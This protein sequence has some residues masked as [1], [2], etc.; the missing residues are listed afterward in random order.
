MESLHILHDVVLLP[1]LGEV[2]ASVLQQVRVADMYECQIL[3][4]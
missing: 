3:Q 1:T 4:D 2:D